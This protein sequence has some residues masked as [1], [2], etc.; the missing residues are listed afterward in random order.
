MADETTTSGCALVTGASGALGGA[1]VHELHARG[2]AVALLDSAH[3]RDRAAQMERELSLPGKPPVKSYTAELATEA[4]WAGLVERVEKDLGPVVSATLIAGAWQGGAKLHEAK[5]D[6]AWRPMMDANLETVHRS[7]RALLPGM[8]ARKRGSIVVIG[9]RNVERTWTGAGAA[10]YTAS[11]A[12][13]IAL[14]Q[15]VAAEVLEDGVRVNA[16]LPSTL[17]TPANRR[18]MPDAD[19]KRWVA[20]ESAAKVIAFLLSD[21]ARDVSGAALPLYGRS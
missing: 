6:D 18:A 8:V 20:T 19:P 16:V 4:G 15:A 13:V 17:D 21:D 10:A 14:A 9:S 1:V 12:A 3:G 5:G 7:L 11:K 2:F